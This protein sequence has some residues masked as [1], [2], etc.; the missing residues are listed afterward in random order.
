MLAQ[1][2]SLPSKLWAKFTFIIYKSCGLGY[3]VTLEKMHWDIFPK[4]A[5]HVWAR[6]PGQLS[7]SKL[8]LSPQRVLVEVSSEMLEW[9]QNACMYL[10]G[11]KEWASLGCH[12]LAL[13]LR[14]ESPRYSE[15]VWLCQRE[16]KG[17]SGYPSATHCSRDMLTS[18]Q[19]KPPIITA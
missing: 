10:S 17:H 18:Y 9:G 15:R 13:A 14:A 11:K 7:T 3:F 16:P 6:Y 4:M 19:E 2:P 8:L 1:C 12:V 5:G